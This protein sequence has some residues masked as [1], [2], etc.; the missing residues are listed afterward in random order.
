MDTLRIREGSGLVRK[1]SPN[2]SKEPQ[3]LAAGLLTASFKNKEPARNRICHQDSTGRPR[4]GTFWPRV[5]VW[6]GGFSENL[7]MIF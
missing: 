1:P 3:T 7:A 6:R 5:W 4:A 2:V